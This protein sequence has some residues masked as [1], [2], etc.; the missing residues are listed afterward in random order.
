[1]PLPEIPDSWNKL[2]DKVLLIVTLLVSVWNH[3]QIGTVQEHQTV[4]SAKLDEAKTA[5]TEAKA[6]AAVTKEVA[7][8]H[9]DKIDKKL[10]TIDKK[11]GDIRAALPPK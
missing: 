11:T 5:A 10:D 3:Q 8:E 2:L 1:M 9:A 7:K 4:N 6:E